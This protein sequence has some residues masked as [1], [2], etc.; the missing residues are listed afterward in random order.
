MDNRNTKAWKA[1]QWEFEAL[2]V[3]SLMPLFDSKPSEEEMVERLERI[4]K[5]CP[6]FQKSVGWVEPG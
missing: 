2:Y 3:H 1:A 5:K 4:Q 6:K